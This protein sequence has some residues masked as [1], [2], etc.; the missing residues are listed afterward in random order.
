MRLINLSLSAVLSVAISS[1]ALAAAAPPKSPEVKNPDWLRRPSGEDLAGV[2]PDVTRSAK[3][4][5]RCKVDALGGLKDCAVVSEF[6]PGSGAG[7]AAL[8]LAPRF[9]MTPKTVD[10]R[11]VEGGTVNIPI[12]FDAGG[13][14]ARYLTHPLWLRAPSA[15]QVRAAFAGAGKVSAALACKVTPSG[16]LEAC[17]VISEEPSSKSVAEAALTLT[18]YFRVGVDPAVVNQGLPLQA[19]LTISFDPSAGPYLAKPDWLE[20]PAPVQAVSVF[21]AAAAKAGLKTGRA[22]VDCL[23]GP[24]GRLSDCR[25]SGEDPA[26]QGFGEAAVKLAG[27]MKVAPWT[28]D[29]RPSAGGRIKMPI[30][31]NAEA[32]PEP[33][34]APAAH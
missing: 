23:V 19:P 22:V 21:P 11:A 5:I 27:Y 10:G 13:P 3:V 15:D 4:T 25:V 33:A 30:R 2:W 7:A 34:L 16:G 9:R 31:L 8:K 6:P 17:R 26:G 14:S 24:D 29:G 18:D 32:E 1:A 20:R 28:L 12:H